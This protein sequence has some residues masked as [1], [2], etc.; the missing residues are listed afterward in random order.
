MIDDRMRLATIPLDEW[1]SLGATQ[2]VLELRDGRR[3]LEADGM[4]EPL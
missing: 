1:I 3:G 2:C 4:P